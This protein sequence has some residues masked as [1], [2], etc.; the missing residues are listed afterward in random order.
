MSSTTWRGAAEISEVPVVSLPKISF[1]I[2]QVYPGSG[3]FELNT[4]NNPDCFNFGRPYET[5]EARSGRFALSH[6]DLSPEQ[7][8]VVEAHG[9]GAYKLAGADA[10]HRRISKAFE[11]EDDP[12]EWVDQRTV[13]CKAQLRNGTI[14]NTGFS[15]LSDDHL[16]AEV[17]RLRNH[18]GVLDGPACRACNTR[19]LAKPEEF[20]LAGTHLRTKDSKGKRIV[21]TG[22]PEAV[23]VIHKPC[24]G[25]KGAK[26]TISVPHRRQKETTENLRIL[27]AL[28]NSAGILDIRRIVGPAATGK[29]PGI[30]RIYDRIAW[31]EQ[32]FLAYEREMLR[33]WRERMEKSSRTVEHR[34]SHDDLVLL[35]NWET[36]SDKRNTQLNVSI[37]A[38]ATSGYVYRCDVDFDPRISPMEEF[39]RSYFDEE[40]RLANLTWDYRDAQ[41][42]PVPRFSWQ[43]PTGRLHEPQFFAACINEIKDFRSKLKAGL[44]PNP[45]NTDPRVMA[46]W[47]GSEESLETIRAVAEGWFGFNLSKLPLRG[48]FRGV[49]TRDIYTKAAHFLLLKEMLPRGRIVLTT[50][51]EA[52]LPTILP[53]IFADEIREDRFTWLAMSFNKKAK[54][55]EIVG[56]VKDYRKRRQSF[57]NEGLYDGRFSLA[58]DTAE[59]TRAFISTYMAVA[60]RGENGSQAPYPTS[61][62][63]TSAFPSLWIRSPTQ[64]SGE[65]D[66]IVGFPILRASLRRELKEIPFDGT[67][68]PDDL[69]DEIAE[70]VYLATLQ[71][72]SSFMNSVR[73]RLSVATRAGSGGAR[74]GGSYIQGAVFNPRTLISLLNIYRVAFNFLEPRPYA[75]PYEDSWFLEEEDLTERP[76][77]TLRYPGSDITVEVPK[78]AR[79]A[80]VK[81]TPAMRHGVDAYRRRKDGT[82]AVPNL[83]RLIY[84]PWLYAG[85]KVGAKLDRSSVKNAERAD[86]ARGDVGATAPD[87][88]LD[89]QADRE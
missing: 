77:R 82:A 48:S 12:H 11:Y 53:H 28:I 52:T 33:R 54:K 40:G 31:L 84:R 73:E 4:C 30:S 26:I 6:P 41:S 38:D 71:P 36:A 65:L 21:N 29:A 37:T 43:R 34:L 8:A 16:H 45:E 80:I 89:L 83:R 69:R 88:D 78:K 22:T 68:L 9:P 7:V 66:K 44:A 81:K 20:I 64:A 27:H 10:A 79:R 1:T 13:R 24:K 67:G 86:T 25:R 15:I 59:I 58:T 85:T 55:P 76:I 18:N 14:C 46:A 60:T 17:E 57:E 23:R 3:A 50:E 75:S 62:Y 5:E 51:Q 32:V 39:N 35:A 47:L 74:V 56:K 2:D 87:P 49:T 70:Q 72:V 61:H 19:F 42:C 63:Q